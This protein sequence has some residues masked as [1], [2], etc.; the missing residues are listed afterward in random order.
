MGHK[1]GLWCLNVQMLFEFKM[2]QSVVKGYKRVVFV[3]LQ[4]RRNVHF[5][6]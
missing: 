2:T 5:E 1:L 6:K 3:V 4:F